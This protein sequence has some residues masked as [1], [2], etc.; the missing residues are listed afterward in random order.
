MIN[1]QYNVKLLQKLE[2]AKRQELETE[3]H[4]RVMEFQEKERLVRNMKRLDK[5]LDETRDR[6]SMYEVFIATLQ[7][8]EA[9]CQSSR[10][11]LTG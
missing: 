10:R 6:S 3:E 5:E 1:T 8:N 11:T 4:I 2:K 7:A 9:T